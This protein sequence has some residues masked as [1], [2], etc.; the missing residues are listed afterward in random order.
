MAEA[1]RTGTT[2]TSSLQDTEGREHHEETAPLTLAGNEPRAPADH[3]VGAARDS[4]PP[5][6]NQL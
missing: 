3:V 2:G 5:R 6:L 4:S 1:G